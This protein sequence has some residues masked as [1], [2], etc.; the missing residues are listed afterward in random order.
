MNR[1]PLFECE[2]KLGTHIIVDAW[3]CPQNLLN[4]KETIAYITR[5]AVRVS[6][7]TLINLCVHRFS[8]HG[9][10]AT[11]TLAESH[12]AIHTWPEHGYLGMD[13]FFCGAGAPDWAA[14]YVI[15][16]SEASTIEIRELSRGML[17]IR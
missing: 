13:L 9:I 5:E 1:D 16:T 10:T 2:I 15:L 11:A 4:D 7:A 3:G 14:K 12:L 6:G 17:P 8:P